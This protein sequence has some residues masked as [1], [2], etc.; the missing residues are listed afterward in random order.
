[1]LPV[2]AQFSVAGADVTVRA[3]STFL[4]LAAIAAGWLFVQ[5]ATA[6]GADRRRAVAV[7]VG[8][9]AAGVVGARAL[10]VALNP[11]HYAADP[12]QVVAPAA[13][14][15]ALYGGLAAAGATALLGSSWMRVD[16]AHLADASV[17]AVAT[18]ITVMRVGCFLNGCCGGEPADLPW[19]VTFPAGGSS[20]G[21]QLLGGSTGALFGHVQAVHPTQL[22]E[23]AAAL[24]GAWAAGFASERCRLPAGG[25]AMLFAVLFLAFR[26]ANQQLRAPTPGGVLGSA[27]LTA[28]YL[29]SALG[30]AGLLAAR[31]RVAGRTSAAPA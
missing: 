14:G 15:F 23:L 27:T 29:A 9:V 18:G 31:V 24:L 11:A 4:V 21:S 12:W 16:A 30:A 5:A 7:L 22:Y 10:D 2:L 3:Y 8:A 26:V 1:M 25:P 28:V 6:L 20:W 13:K 19:A 17:P